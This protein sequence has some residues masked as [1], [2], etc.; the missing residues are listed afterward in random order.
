MK[1]I[2]LNLLGSFFEREITLFIIV[3]VGVSWVK[4]IVKVSSEFSATTSL[5]SL[6]F[7]FFLADA[8]YYKCIVKIRKKIKI[9][10]N[11][12]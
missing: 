1:D 11:N 6:N 7:F 4:S 12:K 3:D 2:Y 10:I 9:Q 5:D 8:K